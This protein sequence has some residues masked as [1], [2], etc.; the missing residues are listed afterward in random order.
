MSCTLTPEYSNIT[1]L[2][3]CIN[4][5]VFESPPEDTLT[6][7]ISGEH[8]CTA[9]LI[10]NMI[11]TS[12]TTPKTT[13]NPTPIHDCI[14]SISDS[15]SASPS[16]L[17]H[18]LIFHSYK[19][20][21]GYISMIVHISVCDVL[22]DTLL[23]TGASVTL[24]SKEFLNRLNPTP[25]KVQ[26]W[27]QGPLLSVEQ[28]QLQVIGSISLRF[29]FHDVQVDWPAA[30]VVGMA[31]PVLIG[32]DL[33]DFL[34][35]SIDYK[36]HTVGI[37]GD[38]LP[39]YVKSHTM[40]QPEQPRLVVRLAEHL[41]VPVRTQSVAKVTLSPSP[42]TLPLLS[43][44]S[45]FDN[46]NLF[47]FTPDPHFYARFN[48]SVAHGV[49]S[50]AQILQDNMFLLL[51]NFGSSEV[52]LYHNTTIGT[53][54]SLANDHIDHVQ[55]I[56]SLIDQETSINSVVNQFTHPIH[57]TTDSIQPQFTTHV[58]PDSHLNEATVS[59]VSPQDIHVLNETVLNDVV[60]YRRDEDN[61]H[62]TNEQAEDLKRLL[63][64]NSHVFAE[65][66]RRKAKP[67]TITHKIDIDGHRPLKQ[68]PY[69]LGRKEIE[70]QKKE[71]GSMLESGVI[72]HSASDW[73][74]PVVIVRK[75]DGSNRFCVDY[76]R[77]NAI[78]K[79]D[80][81]PL[82]RIDDTLDSLGRATIFSTLD[83][84]SGYW[85][86]PM[87]PEDIEKTAF[88]TH[89][90]L[91]EFTVMPFGL[92]NAPATFQR[93]MDVVLS[94]L[95]WE[96]CLVYIDDIII[97]SRSFDQHLRD[98]QSVFS[99][100]GDYGL[101]LKLKK[102][103]FAKSRL[104]YLG[105]V[106]SKEGIAADPDKIS[107]VK[108]MP[109][110]RDVTGIR[111]F[112]GM[113]SYYRRFIRGFSSIAQ[114]L[115]SL[116]RKDSLFCWSPECQ[117]SFEDLKEALTTS[118]IL[119]FPRFDEPFVVFTDASAYGLGGILSQKH[120]ER[121][122]VICYASRTMN[123]AEGNYS[124]TERE[125]LAVVWAIQLFRPYLQG[126]P[127]TI[128]TDHN[129]LQW[130]M[131]MK[132]PTGR[133]ARWSLKLQEFDFSLKY[134]QGRVHSNVDTLSRDPQA[135]IADSDTINNVMAVDEPKL[136]DEVALQQR[137]DH[138]WTPLIRYIESKQLPELIT[139]SVRTRFMAESFDIQHGRLY[140]IGKPTK[141]RRSRKTLEW[142]LVVPLRLR[143]DVISAYHDDITA[144]HLG[145]D[146]TYDKLRTR[147]FWFGMYR[148]VKAWVESCVDCATKKSPRRKTPGLMQPISVSEPFEIVAIDVLGPLPRTKSGKRYVVV[149]TDHFTKWPEAFAVRTADAPTIAQ[150]LVDEWISRYGAMQKLLSDRG[151]IF[152][153][154]LVMGLCSTLG[155][156]KINTTAYHPQTDGTTERFNK[157]LIDMLSMFCSSNQKDWDTY[158]QPVLLAYRTALHPTIGDSPA[159]L[160]FGRDIQLP[161]D[162]ALGLRIDS[163]VDSAPIDQFDYR[164]QLVNVLRNARELASV[165][166]QRNQHKQQ[167]EYDQRHSDLEFYVGELVWL[168]TPVK[169]K[170]LSPKL[171]HHWHGPFRVDERIGPVNYR[172]RSMANRKLT[173]LVHI[174]RLKRCTSPDL[175]PTY[176]PS[177]LD[178]DDLST[179]SVEENDDIH[180]QPFNSSDTSLKVHH[181]SVQDLTHEHTYNKDDDITQLNCEQRNE[182]IPE[183][184]ASDSA[185]VAADDCYVDLSDQQT[186]IGQIISDK[187]DKPVLPIA[188]SIL[189]S[190]TINGQEQY[191]IQWHD[192]N[193]KTGTVSWIPLSSFDNNESL[194]Q[195]LSQYDDKVNPLNRPIRLSSAQE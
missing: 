187:H 150:L 67:L 160:L 95:K 61:D 170:G 34:Q 97:Y 15:I 57:D 87:A 90:G 193:A 86:I 151:S 122:V 157:T 94:G 138:E 77:L 43:A 89:D 64:Q 6:S 118:P 147:F 184:H 152:L 48:I 26:P 84:A 20:T 24:I 166:I 148:D 81:Y 53:L 133:L 107:A 103:F 136:Y 47:F 68:R 155:I 137:S 65:H 112:L 159:F 21:R 62:L 168:Y 33:L 56:N 182:H 70:V 99:R 126:N 149:C 177:L 115:T 83:L 50:L 171:M 111:R 110:P 191:L 12:Q 141:N 4:R 69:R 125:C 117:R 35:V 32:N 22:V 98:L 186:A 129:S 156:H 88:T 19:I 145:L 66:K 132:G 189:E 78:T 183:V 7:N 85:Q 116:T 16:S 105:H 143:A 142:R 40:L 5:L 73:S 181:G 154:K 173:H 74:S 18:G 146:K 134:R 27:L 72:R 174:Q 76:R 17:P 120:E 135:V 91:F 153:S 39:F 131:S 121:E 188:E 128:V 3:F 161:A 75:K 127:F 165:N 63:L 158:L 163:R 162:V 2:P 106:I 38:S 59:P 109:P 55:Y 180:V 179:D 190:R 114:P 123:K 175:R 8:P 79:K 144:G 169:A 164:S 52:P 92:C 113:A 192:P 37:C 58:Q 11:N 100:L 25:D 80:V 71:V 124:T 119:A 51:A 36:T 104:R 45:E 96:C 172:L 14:D 28:R 13:R 195:L 23:D 49:M 101:L 102:C 42:N 29:L 82:P 44:P 93:T 139:E 194:K 130:L 31:H 9:S 178:D 60:N 54:T 1:A 167:I 176:G 30:I 46:K 10:P 41:S 108:L 185:T 140:F